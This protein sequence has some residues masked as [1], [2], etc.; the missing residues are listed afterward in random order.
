ML[1]VLLMFA[2]SCASL[3]GATL[4]DTAWA[5]LEEGANDKSGDK[6]TK[7]ARAL[8]LLPKNKRAEEILENALLDENWRVRVGAAKAL[9]QMGAGS[10]RP[11]LRR[12]LSDSEIEV[13]IAATNSLHTLKDPAA[14]DVYYELLTG[15]RKSSVGLLHSQLHMLN[16]RRTME[17]L[18]FE[19]AIGFVP[20][21]GM[22]YEA[23]K[24]VT[25][26]DTSPV[27]AAAA[28]R[29]AKDP[30]PK[31]G[32]ALADACADKKA[33]VRVA[34]VDAI[35]AREDPAL[36]DALVPLLDDGDDVVR[37]DAAAAIL[38]LAAHKAIRRSRK[39]SRGTTAPS[40]SQFRLVPS[41]A[42]R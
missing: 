29:L 35:A 15:A 30:D 38:R 14:Y 9:G 24:A 2:A 16:D 18:A 33:K 7:A 39:G 13:V 26:D 1:R 21:G 4:T 5:I 37:Y 12:A 8:G 27:R 10:A 42:R 19:T 41:E 22:G 28:E 17:K 11:K 31:S 40:L 3:A 23:W 34:A 6:R 20:F 36:V 32:R 25:N